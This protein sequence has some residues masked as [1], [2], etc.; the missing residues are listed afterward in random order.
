MLKKTVCVLLAVS[1]ILCAVTGSFA[2]SSQ[3]L[4]VEEST[5]PAEPSKTEDSVETEKASEVLT[6]AEALAECDQYAENDNLAL[7]VNKKTLQTALVVKNKKGGKDFVWWSTPVG[8]DSDPIAKAS[9]KRQMKSPV[10]WT[11]GNKKSRMTD[12]LTSSGDAKGTKP[13]KIKN[14]VRFE[15]ELSEYGITVPLELTLDDTGLSARI[16]MEEVS[17]TPVEDEFEFDESGNIVEKVKD[18]NAPP[19]EISDILLDLSLLP[20]FG[21]GGTDEDG[22]IVVP[23][24]CGAVINFNNGKTGASVYNGI[25]YGRDLSIPQTRLSAISETVLFPAFGIVKKRDQGDMALLAVAEE[26]DENAVIR[27]AVSGQSSTSYNSVNFNFTLRSRGTYFMGTQN[28]ELTVFEDG[29]IK[30]GD[31]SVR[32]I[33]MYTNHTGDTEKHS[34]NYADVAIRYRKYLTEDT[35]F[36]TPPA[37]DE[38]AKKQGMPMVVTLDGG[39]MQKRSMFGLPLNLQTAATTYREA[40]KIIES[41]RERGISDVVVEY[42][43]FNE[44]G[45][46]GQ[47]SPGVQYS[48]LL[49]GRTGFRR[50]FYMGENVRVI[51]SFNNTL[52]TNSGNGYSFSGSSAKRVTNA[53]ATIPQYELM[54]GTADNSRRSEALLSPHFVKELYTKLLRSLKKE[55]IAEISVGKAAGILYS[56]FSRVSNVTD[57]ETG[58]VKAR[59]YINRHESAE[60]IAEGLKIL[61]EGG[62]RVMA[63]AP[64]A[65][66][67]PY[68]DYVTDLPLYSSSYDLFDFDFPFAEIV[69]HGVIPYTT[70]PFN[71]ESDETSITLRSYVT[72]TPLHYEFMYSNPAWFSGSDVYR[73]KFY[74]S[75]EGWL[76]K[77]AVRYGMWDDKMNSLLY[78]PIEGFTTDGVVANTVFEGG[79][80]VNVNYETGRYRIF[81]VY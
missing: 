64:A 77:A 56:D 32:Y 40:E 48:P 57:P 17:E 14:G 38:K 44:A 69:L 25:V 50:L 27:A 11:L 21:A 54:Y 68:V 28:N 67:L 74:T 70:T 76:D 37:I 5:E 34:I 31:I 24:G 9:Q 61:K 66:A 7:L 2:Q 19:P 16:P 10:L 30:T 33:P 62:I 20:Y 73:D 26:G 53:M 52:Y 8:A 75:F 46:R 39:T 41:L 55:G 42:K 71:R 35:G 36:I 15:F 79:G 78:L 4:A 59:P 29:G 72:A 1:F 60:Y 47:I 49:G 23:D 80:T 58:Q 51:P 22:Y 45:I 18:P 65:F 63:S 3:E 43:N 13:K 81:G 6:E 12:N